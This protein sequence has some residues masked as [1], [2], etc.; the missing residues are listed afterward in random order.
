VHTREGAPIA[1]VEILVGA[2][3]ELGHTFTRADGTFDLAI[4]GGGSVTLV[5]RKAAWLEAQRLVT[6][7]WNDQKVVDDV[8]LVPFDQ[9]AGV[10]TMSNP[11]TQTARGTKSVDV[12]GE[13]TATLIFPAGESAT[14]TMPDGTTTT[15]SALHIRATEYTI[16]ETGPNAMPA[17]LPTMSGYTYCVELSADEALGGTVQFSKPLSF[18]LENFLSF[19]VG[20]AIP[21]GYYDRAKQS[22]NASNNGRVIR[23]VAI[24]GGIAT[25]DTNGD[26]IAE[27]DSA[28]ALLGFDQGERRALASIYTAGQTLWRMRMNH[29]TPWD[30]NLNTKAP[31]DA[32]GPK[33][34]TKRKVGKAW[35]KCKT[36]GWSIVDCANQ[37]L[38]ESI[39]LQGTPY[40]LEY[41]SSR[42]GR[43]QYSADIELSGASVPASL[44]RI[45]LRITI[46]G[47]DES[48]SFDPQPNLT[49][50]YT[51]DGTDEFGRKVSGAR[52][53][54][55]KVTYVYPMVY[56]PASYDPGWNVP[57]ADVIAGSI[58]LAGDYRLSES[59]ELFLG[60]FDTGNAGFGGWSFSGQRLYDGMGRTLYEP[61]GAERVAD[62]QQTHETEIRN[63]PIGTAGTI[64][65]LYTIAAAPDGSVYFGDSYRIKKKAPNGA[66][67]TVAGGAS[68][69]F[70][71]DGL[72]A[73][74]NPANPWQIATGPDGTLYVI[75]ATRVRAIVNER[76]VTVAG[77]DVYEPGGTYTLPE[78]V[79]ATS[80]PVTAWSLTLGPEGALYIGGLSR[81]YKVDPDRTIHTVGGGGTNSAFVDGSSAFNAKLGTVYGI[82]VAPDGTI[83]YANDSIVARVTT[84][85][86]IYRVP[87]TFRQPHGVSVAADGTL[88]IA[89]ANGFKVWE[90]NPDG[91]TRIFAGNGTFAKSDTA[92]TGL[93]RSVA[94][95][96]WGVK[97]APDG[98]VWVLDLGFETIR[99]VDSVFPP[100]RTATATVVPSEGGGIAYVFESGR[101]TRTVNALNG[102]TV[103][104][105]AYDS[106]GNLVSVTN[107][108]GLVTRI[109]RNA[110]GD[111]TAVVAPNGQ[112]TTL[113]IVGG[114]L[115]SMS[116]PSGA[117][118][119]FDYNATGLLAKLVDRRGGLHQFTY[120]DDGLLIRDD[121]PVGGFIALGRVGEGPNFSVSRSSAEGR[122]QSTS[123]ADDGTGSTSQTSIGRTGL[124]M[125]ST[126]YGATESVTSPAVRITA[127]RSADSR[128]G[129][130]SPLASSS[131]TTGSRTLQLS[132][133]RTTTLSS[134][135]NFL[136]PVSVTATTTINSRTWTSTY[137]AAT[138]VLTSRTPAGR[139]TTSTFD[140][141]GR[142]IAT[143]VPLITDAI[144]SYDD[145]G[146]VTSY[147]SGLRTTSFFIRWS[148]SRRQHHGSA[149]EDCWFLLRRC[150]SRDLKD[151]ARRAH[152][153]LQLRCRGE[154]DLGNPSIETGPSLRVH[155]DR[156][157]RHVHDP[158]RQ[159]DE[160][161]LQP[162]P[163]GDLDYQTGRDADPQWLRRCRPAV[164]DLDA[165][166]KLR[167][168]VFGHD[169]PG[170]FPDGAER[171]LHTLH[172]RRLPADDDQLQWLRERDNFDH[173]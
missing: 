160:V 153:R 144:T 104:T 28:L 56:A 80:R 102:V 58:R 155:G 151:A 105:F 70:T 154:R 32:K 86:K 29:F 124:S 22:W 147:K 125:G 62:P 141:K 46:A 118:Y 149:S 73:A 71:P 146:R 15:A 109:E 100:S 99:H 76:W 20:T 72:D 122:T 7:Q 107:V 30:H 61:G 164:D 17:P 91:T 114:Q 69:G 75:D 55:V 138:R 115:R 64:P 45:D 1:G 79:A 119:S 8:V 162:R 25:I 166:R 132:R 133:S 77:T 157:P 137:D 130:L 48:F 94:A 128:F 50:A 37:S 43:T 53:A 159:F 95:L 93:A 34:K 101:H 135:D 3:S 21:S 36:F 57:P 13:R 59:T 106:D 68:A 167:S 126:A 39:P 172:I 40:A 51:W 10:V 92:P 111:P 165:I 96:P 74:G 158:R 87:G 83:Y 152:D 116:Y 38:G 14:V 85:G 52:K 23:I 112:R 44:K 117:S 65:N 82:A 89:D 142:P 24:A 2:H 67:T 108:D 4:N 129:M 81:I 120:D 31:A 60:H 66:I 127:S 161:P 33:G 170:R 47:R 63:T 42:A 143:H 97:V 26:G 156:L 78:G 54:E 88:L 16:G 41:D 35:A 136:A 169:R 98:S 131:V 173:L 123:S 148:R 140:A 168:L 5:Y 9:A 171:H 113:A 150:E 12:D 6:T 121:D 145:R 163:P 49:Y 103:E 110:S 19:P 139:Q 18:Y 27:S 84:D 90:V 134:P 11:A